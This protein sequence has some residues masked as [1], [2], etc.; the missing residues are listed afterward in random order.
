MITL[1]EITNQ[2]VWQVCK[3]KVADE[4]AD[5]VASNVVSLAEA[6]ATRNEGN[7]A[8]PFAVYLDETPVGFVMIGKGTVG[9]EN[10][11]PLIKENYCLWR[12]MVDARYQR[13]G[14]GKETVKKVIEFVKTYPLGKAKYLWLSYEPENTVAKELYRE[15]GFVENGEYCDDEKIAVLPLE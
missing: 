6:Y 5:F 10:E 15:M 8:L 12:L 2:N 14:Y 1:R 13:K 9:G 4:Q 11:S 3:L 7:I